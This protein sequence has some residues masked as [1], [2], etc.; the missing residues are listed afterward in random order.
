[1]KLY[2][3]KSPD[4]KVS[5]REA[6]L[7]SLP[8]DN[9]LYM[10]EFIPQLEPDF[11]NRLEDYS[12]QDIAFKIAHYFL[13]DDIDAESLGNI[14]V[15]AFNFSAPL[16]SVDEGIAILELFHGP[17]LAFKD[18]GARFMARLMNYFWKDSND[19]LQI[20]VATSGDTGGAVAAGFY[21]LDNI[22]VTILYPQGKVSKLQEAQL[23]S[24]GDNIRALEIKGDFDACQ[25]L[26]K[27]AFLDPELQESLQLSSANSINI[28]RLIPQSFY[29]FN[30]FRQLDANS[31]I[32]FCVPSG[33]FGN[34]TAGLIAKRMGLPIRHMIAATNIN[35]VIPQYL[36]TGI[37]KPSRAK[38]TLSNAMD[39]GNP[40]NFTRILDLYGST[41]NDVKADITGYPQTDE[42]TIKEIL[43]T[44]Q[45]LGYVLDPHTAVGMLSA[46]QYKDENPHSTDI[47]VLSTAH[48]IKFQSEMEKNIP[49]KIP[50]P[51]MIHQYIGKPSHKLV[52]DNDFKQ[53][54]DFLLS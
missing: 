24:W 13:K 48:P 2:S 41:W 5:F 3:T 39:I 46:R 45:K 23:T 52:M 32:V 19:K 44:H 47:I 33:N 20:L 6:V 29:Y 43:Y 7:Q 4:K 14:V 54:K 34:L 26:V 22:E 16:I 10:P 31:E 40:S 38:Q 11:L 27:Q 50:H 12:F 17:T 15:D 28:A 37:F 30:A 25:S 9:G 49:F 42:D 21:G 36:E 18:F 35:D 53:V 51:T 1:M 8:P